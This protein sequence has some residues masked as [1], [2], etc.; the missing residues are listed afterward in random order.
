MGAGNTLVLVNG[1]RMAGAAGI[2]D[3]FVNLNGIPLSAVER[4]EITLAG[5]S[6]VYGLGLAI[7]KAVI[8]RH[9]GAVEIREPE[10]GGGRGLSAIHRLTWALGA[11]FRSP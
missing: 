3:G 8:D 6:A 5:G 7:V 1:R 11:S 4:V 2:E 9:G 10:G